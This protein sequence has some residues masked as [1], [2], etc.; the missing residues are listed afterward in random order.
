MSE[1]TQDQPQEQQS[2]EQQQQQQ[3]QAAPN[4][5]NNNPLNHLKMNLNKLNNHLL[6]MMRNK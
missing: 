2:Q 1:P 3:Q 5:N 4:N 6:K